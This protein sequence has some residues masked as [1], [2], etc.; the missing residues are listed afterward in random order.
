MH[1]VFDR[2][3]VVIGEE[4]SVHIPALKITSVISNNH[5]IGICHR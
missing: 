4:M 2:F 1:P 3:G 5:T